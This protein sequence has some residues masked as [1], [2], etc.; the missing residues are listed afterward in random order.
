M[1]QF[2]QNSIVRTSGWPHGLRLQT[3]CHAPRTLPAHFAI[4]VRTQLRG[5]PLPQNTTAGQCLDRRLAVPVMK[6]N[7]W[8]VSTKSTP[9]TV[10]RQ[11]LKNA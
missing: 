3:E 10:T 7:R 11:T 8:T 6:L 5:R 2:F 9:R 4:L 1:S